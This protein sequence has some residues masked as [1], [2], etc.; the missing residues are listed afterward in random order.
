MDQN[1]SS[2]DIWQVYRLKGCN[3]FKC[4]YTLAGQSFEMTN[5]EIK[6]PSIT[7]DN[8]KDSVMLGTLKGSTT[9]QKDGNSFKF[10]G[11]LGKLRVILTRA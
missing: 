8:N 10:F 1:F 9:V 6:T 7:C 11:A 4:T 3:Q 2:L 5:C